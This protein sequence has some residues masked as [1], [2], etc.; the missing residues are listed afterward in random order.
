MKNIFA[1]EWIV[2]VLRPD[3]RCQWIDF[4]T[5]FKAKRVAKN[6]NEQVEFSYKYHQDVMPRYLV[7]H[8]SE[9]PEILDREITA[10]RRRH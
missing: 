5:W 4:G 10:E 2:T 9:I 7:R 3:E 8:K 6:L 1:R